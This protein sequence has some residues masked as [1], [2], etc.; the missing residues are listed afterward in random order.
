MFTE[1][2]VFHSCEIALFTTRFINRLLQG[3]C[4]RMSRIL[5]EEV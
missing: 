2:C 5:E 4:I 1:P 3:M